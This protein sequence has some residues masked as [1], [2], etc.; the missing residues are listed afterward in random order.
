MKATKKQIEKYE[1]RVQ[2]AIDTMTFCSKYS[3]YSTAEKIRR[4]EN[5]YELM[6]QALWGLLHFNLISFDQREYLL[7]K[8]FD[9]YFDIVYP[10]EQSIKVESTEA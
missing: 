5:S 3:E 4:I 6:R 8:L 7:T 1:N 9:A 10:L 2:D